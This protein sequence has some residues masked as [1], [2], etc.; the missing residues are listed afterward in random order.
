MR[1]KIVVKFIFEKKAKAVVDSISFFRSLFMKGLEAQ[2]GLTLIIPCFVM[3][4]ICM[5]LGV[6][7]EGASRVAFVG[8]V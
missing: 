1:E 3:V 8:Q 6:S 2:G 7:G 4:M 5:G